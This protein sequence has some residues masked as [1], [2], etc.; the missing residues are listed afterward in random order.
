[1]DDSRIIFLINDK[2][3]GIQCQ[4][5]AYDHAE[6]TTFKTLNQDIK[7]GDLVLAQAE[8]RHGIVVVKVTDVDVDVDVEALG[9]VGWV[10]AP[11]DKEKIDGLIS[12][13]KAAIDAVKQ[14]EKNRR[15]KELQKSMMEA[16]KDQIAALQ[17]ANMGD[18]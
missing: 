18:D 15:R 6:K 5:E 2:C 11:I 7:V 9:N 8:A 3:R 4:Y 10:Y 17:I 1:M 13:E 12:D 14:A 16:H